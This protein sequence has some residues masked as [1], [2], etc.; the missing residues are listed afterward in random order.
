MKKRYKEDIHGVKL[1]KP[2]D[3]TTDKHGRILVVDITQHHV[4]QLSMDRE[5]VKQLLQGQV[6][7]P[8]CVCLD[9]ESHK[10]YVAARD[11]DDQRFVFVYDYNVL[12]DGEK[13][14]VKITKLDL[15]TLM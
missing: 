8:T 2:W 5:E 14:T 4:I 13:I 9:E 1:D 10:M 12:T 7:G 11:R 6:I 15:V 3:I